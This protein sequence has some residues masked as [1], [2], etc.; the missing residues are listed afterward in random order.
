MRLTPAR[1][2]APAASSVAADRRPRPPG[3]GRCGSTTRRRW[4]SSPSCVLEG[5]ARRPHRSPTS[6]RPG[7]HVLRARR[8]DGGRPRDDRRGPGRGHV[9]RRHQARHAARADRMTVPGEVAGDDGPVEINAGRGRDHRRADVVEN[10]GDRP[11]QVG[12]HYHFAE[13]NPALSFDRAAARGQ[14]L[15][16]PGR[17]RRCASSRASRRTVE[18][19]AVR[20]PARRRRP[21]RA[22][23]PG[24]STSVG[25]DARRSRP[26][27]ARS[28][29]R[30]TGDR[31]RLADTDLLDRGRPRTA[32]P[33][34]TRP[35]SA[36]AR[37]SASRWAS[38][39][40]PAPRAR[41]T[42]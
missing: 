5:G 31:I 30:P 8:R 21:A 11:I 24:R 13:A 29:A 12:S 15:D 40:R 14:R 33:A 38:R 35:C 9:P 22:R 23:S 2:G 41:P 6:W 19:V 18:L 36:A 26:L 39:R 32:A 42:S 20:R 4:R 10:T 17:A 37:S 28:T 27:R 25:A 7:A 16:D 1:A 34:A 3:A